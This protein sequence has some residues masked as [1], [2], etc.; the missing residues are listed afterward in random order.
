[1]RLL[2]TGGAGFIGSNFVKYLL[3]T[4]SSDVSHITVV[5]KLTYAGNLDNLK[6][7][8]EANQVRFIQGD[9][10]DSSLMSELIAKTDVVVNFAA[11]S[12]VDNSIF[13]GLKFVESNIIGV[14]QI[15]EILK[16]FTH[17]RLIQVSTDEVY[18]SIHDGSWDENCPLQPNSPYSSSKASAD[19]L[20]SAYTKTFN[21][22]TIIT[23]CTN[24]YGPYQ[25]IEKAIPKFITNLLCRKNIQIYGDGSNIREWIHVDDHCRA[26]YSAIT[27]ADNGKIYNVP[28][29]I[30]ISNLNLANSIAKFLN[31]E[32]GFIDFVPDRLGHDFRY[33]LNGLL[34]KNDL[35]FQPII[36]FETGL[37]QTIEWYIEN[38]FWWKR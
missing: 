34:I 32:E 24:N 31:I 28:G 29:T 7:E 1:M 16:K 5:D 21:L 19:L 20:V 6:S 38:K 3:R 14:T 37:K 2:V 13:N 8:L 10:C 33:S 36:Q 15:L 11:E 12:H 22:N 26:I 23:R 9:I 27:R 35:D 30:E 4:H 18:G 17:V 25:N